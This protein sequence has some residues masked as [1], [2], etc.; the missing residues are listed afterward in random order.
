MQDMTA[1]K[2]GPVSAL[3]DMKIVIPA[4][5]AAFRKLDPR[6]LIKNPVI[7]VLEV[8][9]ALTTAIMSPTRLTPSKA[10]ARGNISLPVVVAGANTWL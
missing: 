5:A 10:A 2:T 7:F 8:V 6:S 4:L 9:S 3:I 1:R